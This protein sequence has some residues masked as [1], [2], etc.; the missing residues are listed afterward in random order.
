MLRMLVTS[1]VLV[2]VARWAL[3]ALWTTLMSY[4][5]RIQYI[6][7]LKRTTLKYEYT[8]ETSDHCVPSRAWPVVW[9]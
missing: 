2:A 5:S 3:L 1:D 9:T 7:K 4:T 6:G 8:N